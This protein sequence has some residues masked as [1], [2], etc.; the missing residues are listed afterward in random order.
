MKS[1]S[2]FLAASA[3]FFSACTMQ[4]TASTNNNI[5]YDD[6]YFE[7]KD[8][9]TH[10]VYSAPNP[11]LVAERKYR[12]RNKLNNRGTRSYGQSYRDRMSNFNGYCAPRARMNLYYGNP[13]RNNLMMY[14]MNPYFNYGMGMSSFY[15][16]YTGVYNNMYSGGYNGFYDPNWVY[17]NQMFFACNPGMT[18]YGNGFNR[19]N[20]G[21][22]ASGGSS[23]FNNRNATQTSMGQ[24]DVVRNSK[25]R[26]NS[27][28]PVQVN[29]NQSRSYPSSTSSTPSTRQ[30]RSSGNEGPTNV[31]RST[32]SSSGSGSSGVSGGSKSRS[33]NSSGGG[34]GRR[35]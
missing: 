5:N 7:P 2:I 28:V 30:T 24:S 19:S 21:S 22:N 27:S 8:L 32:R 14:N 1:L 16:P 20:W 23:W 35:R 13:Y 33:S 31:W 6:A 12:N 25:Q 4:R 3:I 26:Y 34:S 11:A 18:F 9:E 17:Y 10:P 29:R 15:S